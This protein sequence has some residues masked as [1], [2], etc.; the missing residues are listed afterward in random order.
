MP[1]LSAHDTI[2][3]FNAVAEQN[4]EELKK[5]PYSDSYDIQKFSAKDYGRPPPGSKTEAR[6]KKAA[7]YICRELLFLCETIEA[8]A[9]GDPPHRWIKF[10]PLFT[11]YSYYSGS[12]VG[13]L[14]RARKYGLLHF[15]GEMLY[16]VQDDDKVITMLLPLEEIRKGLV[17][18]G[19][20]ANCVAIRRGSSLDTEQ[21]PVF[22]P[23]E[24]SHVSE[25]SQR[26]LL[27]SAGSL[28]NAR[29]TVGWS[30][31][32]LEKCQDA[33]RTARRKFEN[34]PSSSTEKEPENRGPKKAWKPK[35]TSKAPVFCT[36]G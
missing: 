20:P 14:I 2:Q 7:A 17:A 16:Q 35:D 36:N 21:S 12:L 18:S 5:N 31:V 19:D 9:H 30:D 15:T 10:G 32:E 13:M 11:T 34:T 8:N 1:I 3:K 29:N 33:L 28:Q 27:K 22:I 6:G 23:P 4:E 26:P 24:T 25:K